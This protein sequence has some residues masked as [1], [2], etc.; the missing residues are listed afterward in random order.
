MRLTIVQ[1][2]LLWEN[3]AANRAALA[4]TLAPLAGHT[5]LVVLPEM[6]TTGFSMN[7]AA[8]AEDMDGATVQWLREQARRLGSAVTGSFICR[9]GVHYRNRLVFMRPDGQ[10]H[11]Y[12]KRHL[13]GLAGEN[14]VYSAGTQRPIVEWT[15]WRICPLVCYDLRFPVWSR[16]N[17]AQPYDLLLY[18]ANWPARRGHH[19]RSLLP[20]RAIENQCCVAAVNIV[21]TDGNG[22]EY[23]GDSGVWDHSGQPL[24]QISGQAAG[25]F[26][27]TLRLDDLQTYRRQ[28]PFLSDADAF[29]LV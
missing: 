11:H 21:G 15:G 16:Q 17:S 10:F 19:W 3:P 8:L 2:A 23:Q 20:A 1:T 4:Q 28:L 14:D 24:C 9:D 29:S 22:H 12:D 13:F 6:F 26:T 27:A 25:T 18:V 5:D 7:A